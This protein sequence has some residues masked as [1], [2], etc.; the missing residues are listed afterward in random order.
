MELTSD[1]NNLTMWRQADVPDISRTVAILRE[2]YRPFEPTGRL[3]V[4]PCC[5]EMIDEAGLAFMLE[6]KGAW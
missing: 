1:P 6:E 2:K 4:C 5:G 3:V